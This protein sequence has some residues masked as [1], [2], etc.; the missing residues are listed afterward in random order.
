MQK[1]KLRTLGIITVLGVA[2]G[3]SASGEITN[4]S[5]EAKGFGSGKPRT[6]E[7]Y[8]DRDPTKDSPVYITFNP[9]YRDKNGNPSPQYKEYG[10]DKKFW[11]ELYRGEFHWYSPVPREDA[12]AAERDMFQMLENRMR[13]YK[14][15]YL[16]DE[17][18]SWNLKKGRST[19]G[20][21]DYLGDNTGTTLITTGP[22]RGKHYEFRYLG[23]TPDGIAVENPYFPP[24]IPPKDSN[25]WHPER[26]AW[27]KEPWDV[28]LTTD[29][30]YDH[31]PKKVEWIRAYFLPANP[32]FRIPGKTDDE[33]AKYWA[34]V[35][36]VQSNPEKSTGIATGFH[37]K[38]NHVY[39]LTFTMKPPAKPNLRMIEFAIT[40][41][42][43][44]QIIGKV[45]RNPDNNKDLTVKRE[46]LSQF[47]TVGKTY[48]MTAKVKNMIVPEL[49]KHDTTHTP[50]T[51]D[52]MYAFDE[53]SYQYGKWD[54]E[55]EDSVLPALPMAKIAYGG[56]ATFDKQN[57]S[58][59][60]W[61]FTIPPV[62]N[63]EIV[64]GTR[65]PLG[66]YE[67][68]DN[69]N[70]ED[71]EATIRFKIEPEDIGVSSQ[72]QLLDSNGNVTV[73]VVPFK[74]YGLRFT[75]N[76]AFGKKEVGDPRD[77]SNPFATVE[78]EVSDKKTIKTLKGVAKEVL[79]PEGKRVA[80]DVP[81]AITPSTSII[82]ATWQIAKL[83]R[84]NGQST[85]FSN[86]GP[87][88]QTWASEINISVKDFIVKPQAIMRPKEKEA[89]KENLTFQFDVMNANAEKQTK[90]IPYVIRSQGREVYKGSVSVPANK[91]ITVTASV[92]NVPLFFGEV[93]FEVEVNPVPRKWFEFKKDG[94]NPYEDNISYN[95]VHVY[96]NQK[97]NA[98]C[99]IV[100]PQNNWQTT[101]SL[102]EWHGH[103]ESY[104]SCH[105]GK[106]GNEHC[107]T[108]YYCVTDWDNSWEETISHYER[109]EIKNV[110][111]RSKLTDDTQGGWVDI[112][113]QPGKVK[114]GYGFEIK[115]VVQYTTNTY[116]ASPK[117]WRSGCSGKTVSPGWSSVQTPQS[118]TVTMPYTDQSGQPV[119]YNLTPTSTSGS[120]DNKMEVYEMP[121]RNV[122]NLKNTREIFVNEGA[123]DANYTIQI[124]TFPFY[125]SFDKPPTTDILCDQ[126]H[127]TISIKGA[128]SDDL[129]THIIQ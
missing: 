57:G 80:I 61:E 13:K 50:I 10:A 116:S 26:L 45:T 15:A 16:V 127:V 6:I 117:P 112:L 19:P 96:Q 9:E 71:D 85:D 4:K 60:T 41:K 77:P 105:T 123:K 126:K 107:R 94:S 109:Y 66:F 72:A 37:Q 40:D 65:I 42:E 24:D 29:T 20:Q 114:A 70:T 89:G 59:T 30:K 43:T 33:S 18:Y 32:N 74:T 2:L 68:G 27:I 17:D 67:K 56:I 119:V 82:E 125:G 115:F 36:S 91:Y 73:D 54:I 78:V 51:L 64:F 55:K 120:W 5:A 121:M 22:Y 79:T 7:H 53:T 92:P 34:S 63:K 87:Y 46:N 23:L 52:Q 106:D 110:F 100:H 38:G 69:I 113:K 81:N 58:V 84:D 75:V 31:D 95:A 76:K 108:V 47:V 62:V 25:N 83:H 93:P 99:E 124:D 28:G 49:A 88:T 39:Y 1:N 102:Y 11:E 14:G 86:D 98:K 118:I 129:K 122:F 101:Y 3:L 128:N 8:G 111:F 103:Q 44:G 97:P 90:D 48:V 35:F 12:T 104:E 21:Q